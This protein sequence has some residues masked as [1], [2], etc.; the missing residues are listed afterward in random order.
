MS[1]LPEDVKEA[2]RQ[3]RAGEVDTQVNLGATS[4][5]LGRRLADYID[6][7]PKTITRDITYPAPLEEMP[8][9]G[10]RVYQAAPAQRE[11]VIPQFFSAALMVNVRQFER[12]LLH[13]TKEAA[14]AHGKALAGVSDE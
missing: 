6:P 1:E 7:P 13:A 8:N 2:I 4:W 5:G 12:G 11:Y 3:L 14:I 10:C 9:S